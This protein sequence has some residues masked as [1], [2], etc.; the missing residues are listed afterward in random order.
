MPESTFPDSH[1]GI[2]GL[3]RQV[4]GVLT[5]ELVLA[6][7]FLTIVVAD[8]GFPPKYMGER[9]HRVPVLRIRP[10]IFI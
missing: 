4:V 3:S 5:S 7:S 8:F 10:G 2:E 6:S 1:T 9:R